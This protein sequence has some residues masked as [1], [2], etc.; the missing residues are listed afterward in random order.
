MPSVQSPDGLSWPTVAHSFL[1]EIGEIPP[2]MQVK[3]LRALQESEFERVGG[4]NTIKVDLRLIAATNRDLP[5]EIAEE[6]FARTSI[7]D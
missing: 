2:A 7:T 6:I 5:N 1:D 4:V 3:L